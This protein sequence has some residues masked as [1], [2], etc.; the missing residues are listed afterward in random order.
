MDVVTAG[1]LSEIN[2]L[3]H[4]SLCWSYLIK[5]RSPTEF[6]FQITMGLLHLFIFIFLVDL[7]VLLCGH[8]FRFGAGNYYYFYISLGLHVILFENW[9]L[10]ETTKL[11]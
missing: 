4:C 2:F 9:P 11:L 10:L 5:Y 6:E 1:F 8:G 7:A 3:F